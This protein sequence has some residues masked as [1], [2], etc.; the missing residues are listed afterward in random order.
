MKRTDSKPHQKPSWV[1]QAPRRLGSRSMGQGFALVEC[2]VYIAVVMTIVGI[3]L[4]L[5]LKLL[6]F[7]RDLE[8]NATDITRSI[9]AGEVWRA[10]IRSAV[11]PIESNQTDEGR[12][13]IIP[14]ATGSIHYHFDQ[15]ALWRQNELA[16]SET[17]FLNKVAEC[18][19]IQET[20]SRVTAWRC[21]IRLETKMKTV[22]IQPKFSFLAV[23]QAEQKATEG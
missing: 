14:T 10:D 16:K 13:L 2:L 1:T 5:Y 19:F 9:K 4:S 23:N 12:F 22:R 11:G 6:S 17:I 15:Q 7:H 3:G 8:R 21:E 18:E 20:R